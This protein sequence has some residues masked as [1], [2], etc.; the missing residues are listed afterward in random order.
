MR[1]VPNSYPDCVVEF[2]TVLNFRRRKNIN[3][4]LHRTRT[5]DDD[6]GTIKSPV[7]EK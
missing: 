2:R 3:Y 7:E 4:V 6:R 5:T 1:I